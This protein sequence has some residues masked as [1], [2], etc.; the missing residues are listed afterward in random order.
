MIYQQNGFKNSVMTAVPS[1]ETDFNQLKE[2]AQHPQQA[3]VDENTVSNFKA[4]QLKYIVAGTLDGGK[5][6]NNTYH[7]SSLILIDFDEITDESAFISKIS[8]T[9]DSISYILWPSISYGFKG[10]RYH[11]AIDPS[12]PLKDKTEKTAVIGMVNQLLGIQSDEA[13]TT[14]AQMF[15]API[16]TEQNKGKIVIHDGQKLDVDEAIKNYKPDDKQ[17][18]KTAKIEAIYH[19]G[20]SAKYNDEYVHELLTEWVA[21]NQLSD[22][23]TFSQLMIQLISYYQHGDISEGAMEDAMDVLAGNNNDWKANNQVKMEEHLKTTYSA[24]S[25]PFKVLFKTLVPVYEKASED[26]SY[27]SQSI[28]LALV[29]DAKQRKDEKQQELEAT[30]PKTK[31]VASLDI[32]DVADILLA[33]VPMWMD[34]SLVNSPIFMYDPS[35]GIYSASETLFSNLAHKIQP[36]ATQKQINDIYSILSD[37]DRVRDGKPAHDKMLVACQNG[38]FDLKQQKL[39]NFSPK[40]HFVA[41]I[42]TAYNSTVTE[43]VIKTKNG[44]WKPLEWLKTLA[45][46]DKE[47]LTVLLQVIGDACQ[48]SYSRRQAVWLVGN[49]E[50]AKVNGSNG[51]STFEALVE[52]IVGNE[53]TAHL[54]ID[55]FSERFALNEL[56]GRA[57]VIGD[58]VQAGKFIEDQSAF[59]SAVTGDTL[60]ADIKNKQP[61]NF[62]FSG[63]IVQSTNEMP[64]FNNQ[65]G[66]TNR[67]MLIVPFMAQFNL[68]EANEE[69]KTD[70]IHRSDVREWL[71][72][73]S[74]MLTGKL[75]K[76]VQPK[77]SQSLLKDFEKG[78]DQIANFMDE[79]E[80]KS[81]TLP[82][83]WAYQQFEQFC[84]DSGFRR[85]L[86]KPQFSKRMNEFGWAK[87]KTRVT[88]DSFVEG[89]QFD[90]NIREYI[91][92]A[93]WCLVKAKQQ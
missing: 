9:L 29:R 39:T 2:M 33:D 57:L 24:N 25:V 62:T 38:V 81:T 52:A 28:S 43:P 87:K 61:V 64:K 86:S 32:S 37:D 75:D 51:K 73:Y 68:N 67:R 41:K 44:E 78:N 31:K 48:S 93:V 69:I 22:E 26:K 58:D 15:S 88:E 66:G 90:I 84:M 72:K 74:L 77:I 42:A 40:F 4:G 91:G 92:K 46:G 49:P 16:E 6:S 53:N 20:N 56:M 89:N 13:M 34:R 70:Y 35:K 18:T 80:F 76:F 55:Q 54:K 65:T 82:V 19:F 7:D 27:T 60:R 85:P 50:N 10:P 30:D 3:S 17:A 47:V 1:V 63:T 21:E 5:R 59:N 8:T 83:R 71:L 14:W 45:N 36:A 12:R 23:K 79:N 11:L